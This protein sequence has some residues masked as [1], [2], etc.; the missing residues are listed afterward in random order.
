MAEDSSRSAVVVSGVPLYPYRVGWVPKTQS[1]FGGGGA[2]PE[3]HLAQFP[4]DAGRRVTEAEIVQRKVSIMSHQ[5][6]E[7]GH[8][9]KPGDHLAR[10]M[11]ADGLEKPSDEATEALAQDTERALAAILGKRAGQSQLARAEASARASDKFVRY[12]PDPNAPGYN[13]AIKERV[14]RI[15]EKAV[16]PLEPSKFKKRKAP[17]PNLEE[18]T[19]L[20][21]PPP[22]KL[23]PAERES[24]NIPPSISNW[25]N[26]AG[27][28]L[29]LEMR[30]QA[31][32][33]NMQEVTVNP[34]FAGFSE[35]LYVAERVAREELKLKQ[36]LLKQK[37]QEA[38]KEREQKLRDLAAKARQEKN[39]LL[40]ARA[41]QRRDDDNEIKQEVKDSPTRHQ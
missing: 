25:I 18:P 29:P 12:I 13:P 6:N 10:Y 39:L 17:A 33:R 11:P 38:E 1:D 34:K 36:D 40:A 27:H 41:A 19:P 22:K 28:T 8:A 23:T 3:V 15:V 32:R 37:A 7:F 35:A 5:I 16:D 14:V 21:R 30:I 2:Y 9:V 24:W 26:P 4:Q 31:D 20:L